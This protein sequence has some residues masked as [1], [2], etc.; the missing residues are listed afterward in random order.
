MVDPQRLYDCVQMTWEQDP[1]K[2]MLS[3]KENGAYRDYT[4]EEIRTKVDLLAAGLIRAG[5][6][7]G[8]GTPE[9]RDKISVIA[10]NRPEWVI[11]DLA[12]QK[13]GAVLTPIYPTIGEK[14]LEFILNEAQV[15]IIFMND[16]SYLKEI[17]TVAKN[18]PKLKTFYTFDT[19]DR[20]AS[21][22]DL[23]KDITEDDLKK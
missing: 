15:E 23:M 20:V 2:V 1:E 8:D 16:E 5:Y 7:R 4:A 19:S 13:I 3:G 12:V 6:G 18:L 17:N 14:E 10:K 9:G 22:E 11:L 21:W